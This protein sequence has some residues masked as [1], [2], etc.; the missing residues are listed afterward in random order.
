MEQKDSKNK[1][2][3][4]YKIFITLFSWLYNSYYNHYNYLIVYPL[5]KYSCNIYLIPFKIWKHWILSFIYNI[6]AIYVF[7]LEIFLE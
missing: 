3:K 2:I 7:F 6:I 1:K 5:L 4:Y